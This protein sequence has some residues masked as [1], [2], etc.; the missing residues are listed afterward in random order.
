MAA[1]NLLYALAFAMLL[2]VFLWHDRS[3]VA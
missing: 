2:G 3:S 1:M